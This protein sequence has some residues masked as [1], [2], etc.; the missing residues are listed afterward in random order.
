MQPAVEQLADAWPIL[1]IAA[2]VVGILAARGCLD[3]RLVLAGPNR[4][5]GL[6]AA[7]LLIGFGIM[8]VGMAIFPPIAAAAGVLDPQTGKAPESLPAQARLVLLSQVL[9]QVP[10]GLYL[11]WRAMRF[12]GGLARVGLLPRRPVREAGIGVAAI[13]VTLPV[14][15][16]AMLL[17]A[18][19]GA[20]LG[21]PAPQLAHDLLPA[22]TA[23]GHR[24]AKAVLIFA[25]VCVAP[26]VEETLYRGLLQS[27]LVEMLG[28]RRR[29]WAIA[30]GALV[31]AMAHLGS[32]APH[33]LPALF[34]LAVI[35]GCLY[36]RT[37]SLWPGIVVHAGFNLFNIA[38]VVVITG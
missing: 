25:V 13:F 32:V 7:D 17:A 37:G 29:L 24:A 11:A 6:G 30:L 12:P 35:L 1:A 19:I 2:I 23:T 20:L 21:H 38:M 27:A 10:P 9:I 26:V 15:L 5:I 16:A 14:V 18:V 33:A 31:F 8:I 22:F 34:V 4:A 3:P 28:R 36:E